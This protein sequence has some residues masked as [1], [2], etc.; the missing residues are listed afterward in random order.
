MRSDLKRFALLLAAATAIAFAA[1]AED[2]APRLFLVPEVL[3]RLRERAQQGDLAKEMGAR[4]R[5]AVRAFVDKALMPEPAALPRTS[6]AARGR[7]M[8]RISRELR[9]Q[10][11]AMSECALLYAITGNGRCAGE[12]KRRLLHFSGWNP[13]GATNVMTNDEAS[14]SMIL[15]GAR[16]YDWIRPVLSSAQRQQV[17]QVLRTRAADLYAMLQ[18]CRYES[19]LFSSHNAR[20]IGFLAEACI[21]LGAE[22][23]PETADWLAYVRRIYAKP[24]WPAWGKGDGGWNEG[25]MYWTAYMRWM[26]ESMIAVQ[27]ATGEDFV[28]TKPFFRNTPW[29]YIYQCPPGSPIS[30]FGDGGQAEPW[31]ADVLRTFAYLQK[32]PELLYFASFLPSSPVTPLRDLVTWSEGLVA[33]APARISPMRRF[34]GEGLVMS[35]SAILKPAENV[36]I[37]FRSS[38]YGSQSHG[39]NDQNAIAL[40]AYGEALL[41]PSGYYDYCDSLHHAGWT[42]T[43]RAQCAVTMDGGRGQ[44][45]GAA[46]KGGLCA[47][48]WADRLAYF[49]GDAA[50]A[51]KEPIDVYRRTVVRVDT[52][53][54]VVRDELAAPQAHRWEFNLHAKSAFEYGGNR[55]VLRRPKASLAATFLVPTEL[56]LRQSDKFDP[57]PGDAAHTYMLSNQ[58]HFTA[59]TLPTKKTEF[60][61]LL[62]TRRAGDET[63]WSSARLINAETVEIRLPTG[64]TRQVDFRSL[65]E[66]PLVGRDVPIAP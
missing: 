63:D 57:P 58:W 44:E 41:V 34:P 16:V 48:G 2:L 40:A 33:K 19:H 52:D 18:W 8:L 54:F 47:Y 10:T 27:L 51:W 24:G 7:E 14:M 49:A 30:P 22:K 5:Y 43:T 1:G 50:A 4:C 37:Y 65:R 59:A 42:R 21:A 17:E 60:V 11:R 62:E 56:E 9:P 6:R 25:P 61:T 39:H 20:E 15:H 45:R 66:S 32:D 3:G 53:R 64:A 28:S 13:K 38:P 46:A 23:Y 31:Q 35:H 26:L 55:A 29:Y 12:A 36:S